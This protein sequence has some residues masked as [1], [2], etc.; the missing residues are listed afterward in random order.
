MPNGKVK[1]IVWLSQ[2]SSRS[3]QN[4]SRN[5]VG[6]GYIDDNEEDQDIYFD[7]KTV[8]NHTFEDVQVGQPVEYVRDKSYPI[9]SSVMLVG[10]LLPRRS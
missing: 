5:E 2:Q 3:V 6:Y 4:P 7:Y 8:K 9:A 1:K 10:A